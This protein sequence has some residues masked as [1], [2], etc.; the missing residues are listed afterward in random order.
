MAQ[1]CAGL[2]LAVVAVVA[3]AY[4]VY[5]SPNR[6][7]S[8]ILSALRQNLGGDVQLDGAQF[9]LTDGLQLSGLRIYSIPPMPG[10]L[11]RKIVD[12]PALQIV[13][14][15]GEMVA[16][17]LRLDPRPAFSA[18]VID[19]PAFVLH[20]NENGEFIDE[21][22][23][24]PPDDDGDGPSLRLPPIQVRNASLTWAHPQI[25]S[26]GEHRIDNVTI[27][28][29][30]GELRGWLSID[31]VAEGQPWG[32]F[33][34]AGKVHVE[35]LE[36]QLAVANRRLLL[37]EAT[38]KH[39]G[40]PIRR[41]FEEFTAIPDDLPTLDS[42]SPSA[43]V[44]GEK[45]VF[46]GDRIDRG[47]AAELRARIHAVPGRPAGFAIDVYVLDGAIA[48]EQFPVPV[49][50]IVGVIHLTNYRADTDPGIVEMIDLAHPPIPDPFGA[51]WVK[52]SLHG[53]YGTGDV[54][55]EA[56]VTGLNT[57]TVHER[58]S[59]Y[60]TDILVDRRFISAVMLSP[61]V[62]TDV[63]EI[64]EMFRPG[65][66]ADAVLLVGA[67][68]RPHLSLTLKDVN[69]RFALFPV[70]VFRIAGTVD[71]WDSAWQVGDA[72]LL[73]H[74]GTGAIQLRMPTP[75]RAFPSGGV[76]VHVAVT[77]PE[78]TITADLLRSVPPVLR[79]IAD[80]FGLSGRA[81]ITTSNILSQPT[82]DV[83][84][85]FDIQPIEM[86]VRWDRLPYE[87]SAFG[88]TVRVRGQ[89]VEFHDVRARR[90]NPPLPLPPSGRPYPS[91]EFSIA[92]S[93]DSSSAIRGVMIDLVITARN[94]ALDDEFWAAVD[95]PLPPGA[96]G[97]NKAALQ[98]V[99]DMLSPRGFVDVRFHLVAQG[100]DLF[101]DAQI[102]LHGATAR[103]DG[104]PLELGE[105]TGHAV[106]RID[107]DALHV[108]LH[109]FVGRYRGATVML[110]GALQSDMTGDAP[111]EMTMQLHAQRITLGPEIAQAFAFFEDQSWR[112]QRDAETGEIVLD[113]DGNPVANAPRL[114]DMLSPSGQFD[115]SLSVTPS[116]DSATGMAVGL[117][118][119][120]LDM[121]LTYSAFPYRL[122]N[123]N[124]DVAVDGG[125]V[126][127]QNVTGRHGRAQ[128]FVPDG[129][130]SPHGY[131]LRILVRD[132]SFDDDLKQSL[133]ETWHG[134]FDALEPAG[135]FAMA[136][137]L[138]GR[139][140]G[141]NM[142][143]NYD[144]E[145][146]VLD[147]A[148]SIGLRVENIRGH[149]TMRGRVSPD[150]HQAHG[151]M[152]IDEAQWMR[153][154][155]HGA[156]LD[157]Q[158]DNG[159][160]RVPNLLAY[161]YGG[162][163]EGVFDMDTTPGGAYAGY[164]RVTGLDIG[165]WLREVYPGS[166]KLGGIFDGEMRIDGALAKPTEPRG[167]FGG[168][169][170]FSV[171]EGNI[172]DVPLV[173]KLFDFANWDKPTPIDEVYGKFEMDETGFKFSKLEL[174]SDAVG[175]DGTGTIDFDTTMNMTF[176][177]DFAPRTLPI[178][179]REIVKL[180][181]RAILPVYVTGPLNN[182]TISA[183]FPERAPADSGR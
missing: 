102:Y 127:V 157:L 27:L 150:G 164:L 63:K 70:P 167:K 16:Q 161:A 99:R 4:Q 66:V 7:R 76:G 38:M 112:L 28:L 155:I 107:G 5:T 55:L 116:S 84:L 96:D 182:P 50:E 26:A 115:L 158:Y 160:I 91:A 179:V 52:V 56:L 100:P 120:L 152:R 106:L 132:A 144:T 12:V 148:F 109:N 131:Q 97:P 57:P 151:R 92:G 175:M 117:R 88:G 98:A 54:R 75:T 35:T 139:I 89:V 19:R 41:A 128:I 140:Q 95:A 163:L 165:R 15:F 138:D 22:V 60:C 67:G 130:I 137:Y 123:L 69:A 162:F 49:D 108:M 11:P 85:D 168:A 134:L 25:F 3:I 110:E 80:Q 173:L 45:P 118:L 81:R 68:P 113:A 136:M 174:V 33:S 29:T 43:L 90:R 78:V 177:L 124:G 101:I 170:N 1:V 119:R 34:A 169:G 62:P 154:K 143:V 135:R 32:R 13:P 72:H 159:N 21:N 53:R 58:I 40:A 46:T 181:E 36:V 142:W 153:M 114:W 86:G 2:M 147:N 24:A 83:D 10:L 93:V 103:W 44:Y 141:D 125:I 79:E 178:P 180:F 59:V 176:V 71:G 48:Y 166:A 39:V 18:I 172:F 64:F 14:D 65:G 105:V 77:S 146:R 145:I 126:T 82:G 94:L 122:D 133:P 104:F 121:A 156:T 51:M 47:V 42:P 171:F 87:L 111:M 17:L 20:F 183:I 30:P 61:H 73:P 6:L 9:T 149:I 31:A 129:T 23:F 37:D 8:E 74:Q